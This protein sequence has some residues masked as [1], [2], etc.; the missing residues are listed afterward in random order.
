MS[1][2]GEATAALGLL[3]KAWSWVT[4]R[5]DPA[6]G[7][8]Q[9]LIDAFEAYG[10]VRQQIPR[11]LPGG[12][13]LPNAIFST[14]DKLKDSITPVLLDWAAGYLT[15][16]RSWLDGVAAEPHLVEDQYS[17]TANYK[18]WFADRLAQTPEATHV[19]SVWKTHD[20]PV[21][22]GD[23]PLCLVYHETSDGLDG[24][25]LSRYWLL[26]DNWN[27]DHTRCLHVMLAVVAMAKSLNITVKGLDFPM[28]V[29]EQVA[30]GKKLLPQAKFRA[31][32]H[33]YPEDLMEPLPGQDSEWRRSL[34]K[35]AQQYLGGDDIAAADLCSRNLEPKAL[36]P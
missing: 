30:Q 11:V 21:S 32:G 1:I 29:L 27:L 26:S 15:I 2:V 20:Q 17:E 19:L 7:Q 5:R 6:R 24:N 34:W 28:D 22:G 31:K 16:N 23:G 13:K 4:S 33:W 35:G 14:P 8:A 9:R 3:G 25:D 10:I 36:S 12:L 18:K